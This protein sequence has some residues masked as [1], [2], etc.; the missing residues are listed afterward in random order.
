MNKNIIY[1]TS[2]MLISIHTLIFKIRVIL[3]GV[4]LNMTLTS[5]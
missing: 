2:V 4:I 1:Y 5:V 3:L